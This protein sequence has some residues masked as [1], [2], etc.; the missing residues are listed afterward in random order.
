M[1]LVLAVAPVGLRA[2]V[3]ITAIGDSL[4]QGYGLRQGDGLVP[5]LEEWLTARGRDVRI[6]NAGV[7]GDTTAGGAARAAWAMG[8]DP[9]AVIVALGG[10][11]VLRGLPARAARVN[12]GAVLQA[13]G[14]RPVL[15]IGIAAPGNFGPDYRRE[16]DAIYPSLAAEYGTLLV[17]NL[18]AA[19]TEGSAL[20]DKWMQGDGIHP[21][22]E[23]VRRIAEAIGPKVL[24]LVDQAEAQQ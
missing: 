9:D 1:A 21:N 24:E 15:L 12:L 7:S 13:A 11:D 6:V 19:V 10:N 5:R 22:A 18:L 2:E 23:G 4:T 17:P 3:V 16:F 20:P 8:D 14:E